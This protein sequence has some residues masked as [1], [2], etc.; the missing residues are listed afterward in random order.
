MHKRILGFPDNFFHR[1]KCVF[2]VSF[3]ARRMQRGYIKCQRCGRQKGGKLL[4]RKLKIITSFYQKQPVYWLVHDLGVNYKTI[5]CVY[6][7]FR[8]A[9]YHVSELE[10]VRLKG[11]IELDEAYFGGQHK[12]KLGRDTAGKNVV[13][14]LLE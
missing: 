5:N 12:G 3:K 8:E 4:R 10:A 2:C 1:K 14:G 7:R 11:E 9:I 13:L 6:Q